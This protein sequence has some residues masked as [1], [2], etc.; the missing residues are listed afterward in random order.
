VLHLTRADPLPLVRRVHGVVPDLGHRLAG[1]AVVCQEA[2]DRP[3][4]LGHDAQLGVLRH[5]LRHLPPLVVLPVPVRRVEQ[6]RAEH[7]AP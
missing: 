5:M 7:L 6:M 2:D 4:Y 3:P 1:P